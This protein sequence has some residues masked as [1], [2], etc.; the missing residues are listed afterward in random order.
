MAEKNVLYLNELAYWGAAS[1][2]LKTK[3]QR[4]EKF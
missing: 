2:V 3:K 4:W 1:Q